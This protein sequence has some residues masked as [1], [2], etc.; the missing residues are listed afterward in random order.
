VSSRSWKQRVQD[1]LDAIA[2]IQTRTAGLT[3]EEFS[4]D[5]MLVES[6]LYQYI[7]LG[8]AARNVPEEIQ[9]QADDVPWRLMGDM[10]NVI[11]HE[12]FQVQLQTVWHGVQE[13]LPLL[14]EPLQRLLAEG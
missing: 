5:K 11:A 3:F 14:V 13:E 9:G 1:I 6:V 7:V 8:E 10:R 12:Y 4:A 2:M